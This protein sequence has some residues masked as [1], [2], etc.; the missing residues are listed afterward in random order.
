MIPDY[1]EENSPPGER[2]VFS[3]LQNSSKNWVAIHSLDLAPYNNNRRTELD[4]V[5][6]IPKYGILCIEVKSHENIH[7]DGRRWQPNSI[8]RSPFKQSLD[9]R[10]ALYRRLKDRMGRTY[11]DIPVMHCC[12]FPRSDFQVGLNVSISPFEFIDRKNYESCRSDDDFCGALVRS[13]TKSIESDPKVQS[14]Q[15]E[16]STEEIDEITNFCSPV[17]KRKPEKQ[18]EVRRRQK[19]LEKTLREQQK[20]VLNLALHNSRLLIE[21]GAGT[22]KSL[23]GMEIAKRKSEEG[24]RVAYV[25]FNKLIGSYIANNLSHLKRP[26]LVAGTVHSVLLSLSGISVPADADSEW[27]ENTVPE[28]VEEILTDPDLASVSTF[29]YIVIDEAQDILARS[30]LWECLKLIIDGGLSK[31]EFLILGDFVNQALVKNSEVLENNLS[32][33]R[34]CSTVWK[35]TENC[36]NYSSIGEAALTLSASDRNTWSG[37]MRTGGSLANW[38]LTVYENDGDQVKKILEKIQLAR[39]NGFKNS[40]ITL[41]TF[42][43]MKK[44]IIDNLAREGLVVEKASVFNSKEIRYST[45]NAF[46]GMENKVIIITDVVITPQDAELQRKVFYTGTTRATENLYVFCRKSSVDVLK[47]WIIN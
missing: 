6:I 34:A 10:Y 16:L 17:R 18:E 9:A 46:K 42:R 5:V 39:N 23:I 26:N 30:A 4:F 29:D 3:R 38:D 28:L 12:V 15:R 1:I 33:L 41:L 19:E 47:N 8:K 24:L 31:G 27:W 14:L 22:G 13:I 36:R 25:C 43:A 45:I 32:E 11:G 44:S 2:M 20:P 37:Y 21:G 40:D 7:F 35:L